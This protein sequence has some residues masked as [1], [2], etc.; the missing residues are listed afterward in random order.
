MLLG[1]PAGANDGDMRLAD[2]D[3]TNQG[4]V[5]IFYQGQWGTVCDNLWNLLDASVVCRALG[6]ENATEALG[7]AAFGPG[8]PASPH[9]SRTAGPRG[10]GT[11]PWAMRRAP[12]PSTLADILNH[13]T[14]SAGKGLPRGS[15]AHC[16]QLGRGITAGSGCDPSPKPG[17]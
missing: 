15:Q 4:R 9:S 2:G 17:S 11:T 16:P 7:Q 10:G 1:G 8:R 3:T 13:T 6:F 14:P 5:E 12:S